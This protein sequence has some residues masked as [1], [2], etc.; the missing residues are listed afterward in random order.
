MQPTDSARPIQD[1]VRVLRPGDAQRIAFEVGKFGRTDRFVLRREREETRELTMWS[2]EETETVLKILDGL[3]DSDPEFGVLYNNPHTPHY[4]YCHWCKP[5]GMDGKFLA[6][7]K[8]V[9]ILPIYQRRMHEQKRVV[10]GTLKRGH[11]DFGFF[12]LDGHG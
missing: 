7:A 5:T 4:A 12:P 2:Q 9:R 1:M 11:R 10:A 8:V 3:V 6:Q